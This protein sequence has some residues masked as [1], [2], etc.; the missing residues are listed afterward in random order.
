MAKFKFKRIAALAGAIIFTA[1]F[2]ACGGA[3]NTGNTGNIGNADDTGNAGNVSNVDTEKYATALGKPKAVQSL[4]WQ[5]YSNEEFKAFQQKTKDFSAKFT[6][7]AYKAYEKEDNF[8]VSPISVFMALS[9]ASECANGQTRE[10]L[11]S[12][13]GVSY[14]ELQANFSILYRSLCT[15][16][17]NEGKRANVVDISN[18]IWVNKDTPVKEACIDNLSNFYYTYSYSA[19]FQN[20]NENANK[21]VRGFVKDKTRGLIDKN[22]QLS[23]DTLFALINTL[24]LKT[25]WNTEGEDLSFTQEPYAFTQADGTVKNQNLL[26]GYYERGRVFEAE[27][28]STFYTSAVGGYKIKFMLPKDGYSVSD[29]FTK[30]NIAEANS[31]T[32]YGAYSEDYTVEH[33]TRC[34][35]PVYKCKYDEELKVILQKDFGVENFFVPDACDFSTLTEKRCYCSKVNHVVDLTVNEKGIEGA[36]VTVIGMDATSCPPLET[37]YYDFVLDRAFGFVI[38][39]GSDIPLFTGVVNN[40]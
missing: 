24:Y 20:D 26:Q 21:A 30:E 14:E 7:S 12:A 17:E 39:N 9:L 28:Y 23:E 2:S 33:Y 18:S 13:L 31:V 11:L 19:D 34:F 35:F 1:A 15:S 8:A 32:D 40:I 6:E 10:E 27:T 25:I 38:T 29:I 22:F 16:Q 4:S 37:V 3:G 36:A 5:E